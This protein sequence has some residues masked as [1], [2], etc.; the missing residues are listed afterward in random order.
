MYNVL[1]R[2]CQAFPIQAVLIMVKMRSDGKNDSK[3][4][5]HAAGIVQAV[6]VDVT[7]LETL[8]NSDQVVQRTSQVSPACKILFRS[9][10]PRF[11]ITS[12]ICWFIT[13]S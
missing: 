11:A 13:S 10:G 3:V 4:G 5:I 1:T 12:L 6:M 9:P 7:A 2:M 8:G